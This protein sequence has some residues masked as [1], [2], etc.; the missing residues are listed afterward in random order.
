MSKSPLSGAFAESSATTKKKNKKNGAILLIAGIALT[1]SIGGVFAAN[2]ITLNGDNELEFGQGAATTNACTASIDA[3]IT[4]DLN[5]TSTN[6]VVR[7]V[8]LTG[9]GAGCNDKT[10]NIGLYNGTSS[11]PIATTTV[12]R[13]PSAGTTP[14]S[15]DLSSL[16]PRIDAGTVKRVAITTED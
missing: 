8:E 14:E 3:V 12:T 6:F 2:S 1:S 11:T 10:L 16:S 13:G 5:A 7:S 4:Q 9:I 15:W